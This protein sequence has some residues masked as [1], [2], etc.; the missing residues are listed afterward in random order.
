MKPCDIDQLATK[1]ELAARKKRDRLEK[2][3][4]AR[5]QWIAR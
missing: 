3:H 1:V 2:A 4:E 5:A